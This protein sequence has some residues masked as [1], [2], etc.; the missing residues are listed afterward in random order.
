MVYI[1]MDSLAQASE[2]LTRATA[3]DPANSAANSALKS[4]DS[5]LQ[6]SP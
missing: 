2:W 5:R 3:L 1:R 4:V 6:R